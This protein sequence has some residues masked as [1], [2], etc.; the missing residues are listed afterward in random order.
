M[1]LSIPTPQ[2]LAQRIVTSLAQQSFTASDGSI[3]RLDATA[4]GTFEQVL[5][6]VLALGDYET[7]LFLQGRALEFLPSTATV[8][9]GGL[10]PVHADIWGVPRIGPQASV[11]RVVVSATQDVTIPQGALLTVDG[12]V[13]W[14]L[15]E[16]ATV[17]ANGSASLAVTCTT[18]GTAGNLTANTPLSFVSPIAGISSVGVDQDGLAGGA[19][20]EPVESWRSRIIDKIRNPYNGG[21]AQDYR[22]W[23]LAAGVALVHVVPSYTGAGTVGVI[24]AMSGPRVPTSE[25]LARVQAYIDERR[26]IRGNATVYGATFIPQTPI[27]RLGLDNQPN[28]QKVQAALAAIIDGVG[29]GGTLY[30]EALQAALFD[31]VGAQSQLLNPGADITFAANEMPVIDAVQWVE[32]TP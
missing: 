6:V 32:K 5:S 21:T 3:V 4:P 28:R 11:G 20:S 2:E 24:V 10:L 7:Y 19:D 22:T 1:S 8:G 25:E 30:V 17:S 27:V 31:T 29:I 23:A 16:A 18:T 26:P 13:Q 9:N 14:A 15:N 12:S